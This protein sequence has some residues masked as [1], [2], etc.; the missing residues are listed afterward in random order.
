[1]Q[2]DVIIIGSG[3]SGGMAAVVCAEAGLRVAIIEKEQLPRRKVCA[4]GLVKRAAQLLP[5]D[6]E[7]PIESI[8]HQIALCLRGSEKQFIAE[9]DSLVTMVTR[10]GL[11]YAIVQHAEKKGAVVLDGM[12]VKSVVPRDDQVEV[13]T[14]S[15][16]CY[17]RFLI[18]A[19]GAGARITNQFW[20]D[21]R[22]LAPAIESE[23]FLSSESM[24]AFQG[25]ARFDFDAISSGYGWVFPKQDHISVGIAEFSKKKVALNNIFDQ[26]KESLGILPEDHEQHRKGYIIPIRPRSGPYMKGRMMLVGDAAG[27]A[28]PIT[29]EGFTYALRSG[30]EAGSALARSG[31]PETVATLYHRAI[32]EPIVKELNIIAQFSKP[33]YFSQM[34]RNMLF[35]RYGER[36]CQGMANVIEGKND[37]VSAVNKHP[38]LA[39]LIRKS[40]SDGRKELKA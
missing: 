22:M 4:G 11:D 13:T 14:D 5:E 8:C 10:T 24:K 38:L 29:A 40:Y 3:P 21:D 2:Y 17:G 16:V 12:E 36:L 30:T 15:D 20:T 33:F 32:S 9:R 35:E 27:F 28:D 39:T 19:E 26:Y 23:V 25:I 1:M 37:Y 34:L 31:D 18:L 6:L 7:F